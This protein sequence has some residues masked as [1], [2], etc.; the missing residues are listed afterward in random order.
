M[1]ESVFRGGLAFL[2]YMGV[3]DVILPFLLVF[4]LVFA[5][6]EKTKVLGLQ[7]VDKKKF[8]KTNLNSLVAFVTAFFVVASAELVKLINQT[9]S[10]VFILLLLS[11]MFML[12]AGTF[13]KDEEFFLKK[14]HQNILM[15]IMGGVIILMF[16]NTLGWLDLAYTFLMSNWQTEAI[17]SLIIIAVVIIFIFIV[18][19]K[20]PSVAKKKE[21]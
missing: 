11:V 9:V 2:E 7:E 12:V 14:E 16:F 20:N 4:T 5:L 8:T 18:A 13:V 1:S 3:Y 17:S 10:Q 21:D 6:L 15:W 19:G